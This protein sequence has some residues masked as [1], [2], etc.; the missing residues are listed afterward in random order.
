MRRSAVAR[1]VALSWLV[2]PVAASAT[3]G[4][5]EITVV[6]DFRSGDFRNLR[7]FEGDFVAADVSRLDWAGQFRD[8]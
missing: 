7:G 8:T 2:L 6:D 1:F 3:D 4:R 5:L